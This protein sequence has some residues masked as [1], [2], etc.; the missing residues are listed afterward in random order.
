MVY[1]LI[2]MPSNGGGGGGGDDQRGEV[3]AICYATF[4]MVKYIV[5]TYLII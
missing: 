3:G 5:H 1:R 4:P 2:R